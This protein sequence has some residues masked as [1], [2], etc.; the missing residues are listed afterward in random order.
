V[1][2]KSF[3]PHHFDNICVGKYIGINNFSCDA[4]SKYEHG[5]SLNVIKISLSST[6]IMKIHDFPI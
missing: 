3:A 6:K 2:S 4:K 1:I 5:D